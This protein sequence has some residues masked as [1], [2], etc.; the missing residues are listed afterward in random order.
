[1][2]NPFIGWSTAT[3]LLSLRTGPVFALAPP[4]SQML[5]P[6]RVK[7][8]LTLTLSTCLASTIPYENLDGVDVVSAAL[9]ECLLGLAIAFAFQAAFAALS[10]AGRVLDV[11]AGYGL[12]MIIDPG[13]RS[14]VPMLGTILTMTAGVIFF[15]ENGHRDLLGL[16]IALTQ[17]FPP[18]SVQVVAD[19]AVFA[20]YFGTLASV[21]LAATAAVMLTLFLTDL[22]IAFLAR[23]LPQMNA[24]V[25]G[26][27]VK[28]FVTLAAMALSAGALTPV[29]LRLT[30]LAL[31]FVP[32]AFR[33]HG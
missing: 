14:Q 19:P 17:A 33:S 8:A 24:L 20:S 29:V 31:D 6:M 15:A 12:A 23:A 3:L 4:F 28:A 2:A 1:M 7:A 32:R 25:L 27:Q 22:A 10:F 16:L 13:S 30:R 9:W 18:A 11:Q 5:I 21:A 26:F